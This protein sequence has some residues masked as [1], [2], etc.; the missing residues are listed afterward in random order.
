[1]RLESL[2]V[3]DILRDPSTSLGTSVIHDDQLPTQ[4][5]VIAEQGLQL[6]HL[7]AQKILSVRMFIR[8]PDSG[9]LVVDRQND[10]EGDSFP[11]ALN[12]ESGAGQLQHQESE[13]RL[14]DPSSESSPSS[15]AV[16]SSSDE[17]LDKTSS[18][19]SSISC[20]LAGIGQVDV[21][22]KPIKDRVGHPLVRIVGTQIG[23]R[24]RGPCPERRKGGRSPPFNLAAEISAFYRPIY[25]GTSFSMTSRVVWTSAPT[26]RRTRYSPAGRR[27]PPRCLP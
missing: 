23:E 19:F 13:D 15:S 1:M 10:G 6:G 18:T 2:G 9:V 5:R 20:E 12:L 21:D 25:P 8:C 11:D 24:F 16:S 4:V 17:Y 22:G 14:L 27:G 26:V 7:P 3:D